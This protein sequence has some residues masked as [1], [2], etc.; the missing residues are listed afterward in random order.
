M[1]DSLYHEV[2]N[3]N[4]IVSSKSYCR[5]LE[6]LDPSLLEKC[7]LLMSQKGMLLLCNN[8]R[9]NVSKRTQE[10]ILVLK[11]LRPSTPQF[12]LSD[13]LLF[14]FLQ[15]FLEGKRYTNYGEIRKDAAFCH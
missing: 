7:A 6:T 15:H 13:S 12:A 10:N 1:K 5:K 9:S 2:L 3:C 8:A 4:V 14:R 11:N